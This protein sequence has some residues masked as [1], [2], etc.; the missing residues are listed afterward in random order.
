MNRF[1]FEYTYTSITLRDALKLDPTILNNL[2]MSTQ[3]RTTKLHNTFKAYYNSKSIAGETIEL[4]KLWIS[5]K[6]NVYKDYYEQLLDE[7]E[8][9]INLDAG[10][11]T[12]R[13][14]VHTG[15]NE[16]EG[17]SHDTG[18][19]VDD[20]STTDTATGSENGTIV[21]DSTTAKTGTSE[22]TGQIV[23]DTSATESTSGSDSKTLAKTVNETGTLD[24]HN[25]TD[26]IDLPNRTTA[27]EYVSSRTKNIIDNDTT[28][29]LTDNT[30]ES[31]TNTGSK[32]N[33]YDNTRDITNN[34]TYSKDGSYEKN[35]T[36]TFQGGVN[37]I[38]QRTK[39]LEYIRNIYLDFVRQFQ[40]CFA[41]IYA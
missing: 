36:D 10:I 1:H 3:E 22:D 7:Y 24:E 15:T 38:E 29:A 14:Q 32:T 28:K 6:F 11:V 18:S 12:T 16:E 8:K 41:C 26:N 37:V 5:D 30:T 25:D 27:G 17:T 9:A 40:D 20:A 34:N 35:I 39:A 33:T 4:F 13:T 21:D 2:Q 19:V 31:G 23:D